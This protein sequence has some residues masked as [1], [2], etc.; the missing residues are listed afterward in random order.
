MKYFFNKKV[1]YKKG[2]AVMIAV[3]MFV[4][5]SAVISVGIAGPTVRGLQTAVSLTQAKQSY[6]LSEAGLEDAI[7]R[8]KNGLTIDSSETLSLNGQSV[9]TSITGPVDTKTVNSEGNFKEY[10]RKV[11]VVL[12]SGS[13]VAFHYG[14]Q[15]DAG[16][17]LLENGSTVAG[18]VYS[19]GPIV[20]SGNLIKGDVV[21][22]D[23]TGLINGI[24]ATSSAFAHT[25]QGSTVDRD[26][27]YQIKTSTTVLGT[28]YPGS[29]DQATT[30]L[31]IADSLI[32]TW[33]T[34]AEDAGI[35]SC[36]GTLIINTTST[37]G[38]RKY[39]C[40]IKFDGND[41]ITLAG[42][43]WAVGDIN[44]EGNVILRVDASLGTESV[45]LIADNPSNR[46]TSSKVTLQNN[47]RYYGSGTAGS[48]IMLVSQ[49]N[50]AQNGGEELAI[51]IKNGAGGDLLIY[52][53]H[54]EVLVLNNIGIKELSAYKIHLKNNAEVIYETGVASL[55]FDSGPGGGYVIDDWREVE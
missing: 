23:S 33:K 45:V 38:P 26:A 15:A 32:E 9:V 25:I 47:S 53:G 16:G 7:Y 20:G 31:P 4:I 48:Y 52:S 37:I 40:N 43:I 5:I 50:S 17:I 27:Y 41:T 22:A 24:H 36:S 29:P 13:G 30:S 3:I 21:S 51:E 55:L 49:N 18:N 6:A 19:N 34:V 28:S 11:E 12:S 14:M 39:T 1:E 8:L 54:G 2:Q 42:P 46:T 35:T 10:V 44:I